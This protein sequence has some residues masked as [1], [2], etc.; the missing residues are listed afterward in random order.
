MEVIKEAEAE[1][2]QDMMN[3]VTKRKLESVD[4][5]YDSEDNLEGAKAF[6]EK[7]EPKWKGR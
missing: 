5:L 3:K 1:S 7:R 2:F 4:I 6:A